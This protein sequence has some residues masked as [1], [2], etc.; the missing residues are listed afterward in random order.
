MEKRYLKVAEFCEYIGL[1]RTKAREW[2]AEHGVV[3]KIGKCVFY[4][5]VAIDK[6]LDA[7]E[8][9]GTGDDD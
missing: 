8:R 4:D 9:D 5:K 3:R 2:G 6:I 7:M 1:G